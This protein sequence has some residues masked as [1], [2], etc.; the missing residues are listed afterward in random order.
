MGIYTKILDDSNRITAIFY[1]DEFNVYIRALISKDRLKMNE[2]FIMFD[3][4]VHVQKMRNYCSSAYHKE[5][6]RMPIEI[7]ALKQYSV[8]K[9]VKK[10][11]VANSQKTSLSQVIKKRGSGLQ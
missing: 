11:S 6:I 10:S 8:K 4:I 7:I 3:K 9:D 5:F 2:K 1:G